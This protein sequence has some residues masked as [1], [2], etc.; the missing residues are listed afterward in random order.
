MK[1][2]GDEDIS[3]DQLFRALIILEGADPNENQGA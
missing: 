1:A 3:D 2:I